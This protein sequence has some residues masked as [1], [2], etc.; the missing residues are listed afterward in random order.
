MGRVDEI[1]LGS[2]AVFQE[3]PNPTTGTGGA[4]GLFVREIGGINPPPGAPIAALV[5]GASPM[6]GTD[7]STSLPDRL[8][9][10]GALIFRS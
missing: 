8:S 1:S 5:V 7:A 2:V 4:G 6:L 10:V 3:D 9:T